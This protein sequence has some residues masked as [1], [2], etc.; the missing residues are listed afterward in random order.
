MQLIIF[1]GV[2]ASGKSTFYK[3][4]FYKTHLRINLDMLKTRHREKI[5]FEACI[6]S[7]SKCVIDNTN[8]SKTDRS[9]YIQMA[10]EAGFL[11][12]SYYFETDLDCA[13][14][15]NRERQGKERIPDQGVRATARKFEP[16]SI[17]EGFDEIYK[18][19]IIEN[20]QF[21]IQLLETKEE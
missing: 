15:R 18:V 19:K 12:V 20:Q 3:E 13:L 8:M 17:E 2:Q 1:I 11:I 6:A 4:Y 16:P 5:L 14:E 9:R 21:S 7:K 10:K